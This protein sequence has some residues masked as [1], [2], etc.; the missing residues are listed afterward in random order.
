MRHWRLKLAFAVSV[1]SISRLFTFCFLSSTVTD[2][3]CL[4][5]GI[6]R[7]W[8]PTQPRD[9]WWVLTRR[10]AEHVHGTECEQRR[11][12]GGRDLFV[13]IP[14]SGFEIRRVGKLRGSEVTEHTAG[15]QRVGRFFE[16]G[17]KWPLLCCGS[18]LA[19]QLSHVA[20]RE[21]PTLS[22]HCRTLIGV[23]WLEQCHGRADPVVPFAA[24]EDTRAELERLGATGNLEFHVRQR[25]SHGRCH[26]H[27]HFKCHVYSLGVPG[28]LFAG[29]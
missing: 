3:G 21:A 17:K 11:A 5:W 27:C 10:Y 6:D 15:L 1:N 19:P 16:D 25:T 23:C 14:A 2:S 28:I 26:F 22:S 4:L 9:S 7:A 8:H 12:I 29:I 18:W 13:G 20:L 24:A